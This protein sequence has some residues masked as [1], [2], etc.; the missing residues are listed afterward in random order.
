MTPQG[1][2]SHFSSILSLLSDL[3]SFDSWDILFIY[4]FILLISRAVI[5]FLF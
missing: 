3:L 5:G 1:E 4:L 2:I